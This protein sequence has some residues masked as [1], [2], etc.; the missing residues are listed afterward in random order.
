MRGLAAVIRPVPVEPWTRWWGSISSSQPRNRSQK[1]WSIMG[2]Y[3]TSRNGS[4]TTARSTAAANRSRNS[5]WTA[6]WAMTVPSEVQRWPAVPKPLNRAP[7]TARSSSASGI[8]TSG[9]LPPSSRQGTWRWRPQSSPMRR[10][11]SVEP[12]KPTLSTR[13][14]SRAAARPSKVAGPSAWTRL[15]TPSGR[16]ACQH[17]WA[18]ASAVAGAHSAGFQTTA[19]PHSSAGTRYQDGTATGKLP[20]V[21]TA[22]TPTG[23]RKVNSCLSGIS[24]GTVW[25]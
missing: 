4:P 23:W 5:S 9:F 1:R 20:A 16:P 22:A 15:R 10:P 13:P 12:V 21:I 25:P 7:S 6:R 14:A 19:L 2:P 18:R 3:S 11:T 24:L 17:S 8:T